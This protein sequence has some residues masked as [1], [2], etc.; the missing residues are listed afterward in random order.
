MD[1]N[2]DIHATN[3][4][5]LS[6]VRSCLYHAMFPSYVRIYNTTYARYCTHTSHIHVVGRESLPC[7]TSVILLYT[8]RALCHTIQVIFIT[9]LVYYEHCKQLNTTTSIFNNKYLVYIYIVLLVLMLV[10]PMLFSLTLLL[11]LLLLL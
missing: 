4:L 3:T 2:Y 10:L 9:C 7:H 8:H 6:G 5:L 11:L 1:V